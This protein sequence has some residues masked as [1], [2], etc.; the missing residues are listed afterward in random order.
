MRIEAMTPKKS[1]SRRQLVVLCFKLGGVHLLAG[2]APRDEITHHMIRRGVRLGVAKES[3]SLKR[4][5]S[6]M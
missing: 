2:L 1:R 5:A 6:C 3:L 4:K